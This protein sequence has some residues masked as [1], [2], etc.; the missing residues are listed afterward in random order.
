MEGETN[1][2]SE[3]VLKR[4]LLQNDPHAH[5]QCMSCAEENTIL[6]R[7]KI[8]ISEYIEVQPRK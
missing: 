2:D 6:A 8:F 5:H 1:K 7:V 3:M 4:K